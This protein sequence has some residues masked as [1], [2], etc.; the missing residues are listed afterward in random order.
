[1]MKLVIQ[2]LL[3]DVVPQSEPHTPGSSHEFQAMLRLVG[4]EVCVTK[5]SLLCYL[6]NYS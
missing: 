5:F 4:W 1:M 2:L 3:Q 6:K